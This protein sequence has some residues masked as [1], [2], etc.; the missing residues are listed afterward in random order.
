[1][2]CEFASSSAN[3][4]CTRASVAREK[5]LEELAELIMLQS[6]VYE[7]SLAVQA[8]RF[9][10]EEKGVASVEGAFAGAKD[11]IAENIAETGVDVVATCTVKEE[12]ES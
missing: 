2:S 7:P 6:E 5:G 1:M 9:V 4:A 12:K 3:R 10:S 11:I 8:E